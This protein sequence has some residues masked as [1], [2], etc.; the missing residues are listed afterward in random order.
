MSKSTIT[1]EELE[2]PAG[3]LAE[4]AGALIEAEIPVEITGADVDEDVLTLSVEYEKE[5][6][7]TIHE[8]RDM[9]S[10]YEEQDDGDEDDGDDE[11]EKNH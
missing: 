3:V 8:V 2:V 6:R 4:V 11:H 1:R 5:Q 9:I 10:D 7:D